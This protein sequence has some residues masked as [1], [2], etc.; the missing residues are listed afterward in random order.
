MGSIPVPGLG[1]RL[2]RIGRQEARQR[3]GRGRSLPVGLEGSE[4]LRNNSRASA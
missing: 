2:D 4:A 1:R 3:V